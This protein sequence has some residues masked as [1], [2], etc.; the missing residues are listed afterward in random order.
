[1]S[2]YIALPDGTYVEMP[3][4]APNELVQGVRDKITERFPESAPKQSAFRQVADIPLQVARGAIGGVGSFAEAFGAN[5]PVARGLNT[6]EDYVSSYLS[7]QSRKDSNEMGRIMEEAKGKGVGENVLAAGRAFAVAPLDLIAQGA[8]SFFLPAGVGALS[9]AAKLGSAADKAVRGATGAGMVVGAVKSSIY[10]ETKKVLL[11]SGKTPEEAES[12]AQQ[13]Q[14]YGG[15]NLDQILAGAGLGALETLTGVDKIFSAVRA[16]ETTGRGLAGRAARGF[17]TE[18]PL[19]GLQ[20]GQE[21]LA[22]NLAVG[23]EGFDRDPFQGVAGRTALDAIVGGVTGS[24]IDVALGKRPGPPTT[25]QGPSP[26]APLATDILA[27]GA[28]EAAAKTPAE[29]PVESPVAPAEATSPFANPADTPE[30]AKIRIGNA[31]TL[32]GM[33]YTDGEI[34]SMPV[35]DISTVIAGGITP[36]Q[37]TPSVQ[38]PA[39]PATPTA[40]A[41][42][43][44]VNPN[45]TPAQAFG[46]E[47][48]GPDLVT[49]GYTPAQINSLPYGDFES[50]LKGAVPAPAAQTPA[51]Q[52]PAAQVDPAAQTPAAGATP[53]APVVPA[54]PAPAGQSPTAPVVPAPQAPAP[55]VPPPPAAPVNLPPALLKGTLRYG[56]PN[57]DNLCLNFANDVDRALFVV[58]K[59]KPGANDAKHVD[60]LKSVGFNDSEIQT[61]GRLLRA[62]LKYVVADHVKTGAYDKTVPFDFLQKY[63]PDVYDT[64]L[65]R[66]P[67][68]AGAVLPPGSTQ[69]PQKAP[70]VAPLKKPP[71]APNPTGTVFSVDYTT[72]KKLEAKIPGITNV[73]R[74]IHK[75]LFPGTTMVLKDQYTGA[76]NFG[77]SKFYGKTVYLTSNIDAIVNYMPSDPDAQKQYLL[78]V[79][80]HEMSHPIQ[81]AYLS[82]ATDAQFRAIYDQY[83]RMRNP[84]VA[85]RA[86]LLY[87]FSKG[88]KANDP[89]FLNK[90]LASEKITR[91]EF[92]TYVKDQNK[93]PTSAVVA[94]NGSLESGYVRSFDEWVGEQGAR[95]MTASLENLVPKTALQKFQKD[96]LTGLRKAYDAIASALGIKPTKGAFEK[97]MDSMY[98][99][100]QTTTFEKLVDPKIGRTAFNPSANLPQLILFDEGYKMDQQQKD[101][102]SAPT[103]DGPTFR[104]SRDNV[105]RE[106][107]EQKAKLDAAKAQVPADAK[108]WDSYLDIVRGEE[109][110]IKSWFNK[111]MRNLVGA[112]PGET[113]GRALLRNTTLSNE[114]FLSRTETKNLGKFLESHQNSTG[115]VMGV[116]TI[117]PLG[118]DPKTKSFFYHDGKGDTSLLKI[119]EK[120]G[121]KNMQ[122]AQ[123][124]MLAQREL[125]LRAA[126][127]VDGK[128]K[129]GLL[130]HPVTGKYMTD[131][132]LQGIVRSASPEVLQASKEFQKFNDKMVEM[133]IQTGL[134]PRSLGEQ[135]KTLMYTPMYRY[136]DE[137]LKKDRNITLGGDI[138][139]AIKDPDSI[140]AFNKQLASGGAVAADLYQNLLRNYNAIVSAAIRNVAYQET[141]TTL[142]KV[143]A[144]DGDST[145]GEILS[146]PGTDPDTG[147]AT[148]TYRVGGEDRHLL[149]HDAPMFQA[150]AALSPQEKNAFVRATSFY[151]GL[152]RTGVTSTPGF[153]LVNLIRGLVEL[154]IK[155]GMPVLSII[156][157]TLG[158]VSDVW[159]KKGAY[160]DIV[161]LTG[162]GGFGFGSGY[163]NQADYMKREYLSK[164]KPLNAW[165]GFLRAFD[166]LE[167]I[168]EVTEMAPRIAYYNYLLSLKDKSGGKMSKADAAWEAVNLVN[169]HR[170]GAGNGILGNAISNLI[171]LTPFLTA[172]IQGLYRLVET[173]TAGAPKSLVGKGVIGIPA[174]IVTRGLMVMFINAGVNAMYGDD[175]WY[176]KLSVKDRMSNMYVK[177]GDTVLALPRA[178]EVGELFG[179]LPTLVLD[180]IRKGD[181]NDIAV[182]V[183]EF[184]KKTFLF[185]PIPQFAKPIAEIVANKNF[186]T[187]QPIENLTDRQRKLVEERY[188]EYTSSVAKYA[189]LV[190]KEVGLSPKQVDTLIRG[191]LGTMATLFLG[192][193]DGVFS[194][195][196]TRPAGV[197]G[198]PSS[199]PGL[200][201][202][203]SGV[204]RIL[205][206][207]GQLNNKFIGDFYDI[208]QK[209]TE[210]TNSMT[211]AARIGDAETVKKRA[212]QMPA[213]KGLYTA[214]NAANENLSKINAQMD[215]IRKIPNLTPEQK[216]EYL[217]R[218]RKAKGLL[219]EQMVAAAARVGVTP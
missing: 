134:I 94:A 3:D 120:V 212:D 27:E 185:E 18:A 98:G 85:E 178:Y 128:S 80:F 63:H 199:V 91:Q 153:Q 81:E 69:T 14:A 205:K 9:R 23:R 194:A 71:A 118:Y 189:G 13:A 76:S 169:Y 90:F 168:G 163:K 52:T 55:K 197:F 179:A 64:I 145:I 74:E 57:K 161:G 11:E 162:F 135:F 83:V 204:S 148:I 36:S 99:K 22:A 164:E 217:E 60:W 170:H 147:R 108:G 87:G 20:G 88:I 46:R 6:A 184:A 175:E 196:G 56:A 190:T 206:T 35:A 201:A 51:A 93:F 66:A 167:H 43:T 31:A 54:S 58:S 32:Q 86:A 214:F 50:I 209:V 105:S 102:A 151:T 131:G 146:K 171:P 39:T 200:L 33:G 183:A 138:Y 16:A 180:S 124:V 106:T 62:R 111:A 110:G 5:N 53:T 12:A 165:N 67:G 4:N 127:Q 159:N 28:A 38:T 104:E 7:A 47:K 208:K 40:P 97:F 203:V 143:M 101:A 29:T 119:F 156:R 125:A 103:A 149:I 42:A 100:N 191:Y 95:W 15:K 72:Q 195:G 166:K 21:Q 122:Q 129:T 155:T 174:A 160:S 70:K 37:Y 73:L 19:E 26:D 82:R 139:D 193:V 115:R 216:T 211:E 176:K 133:A 96:V 1:M 137:V 144:N 92:D 89:L 49:L 25:D 2:Y 78:K 182:G 44:F 210:I 123:I 141:A 77:Q 152:L 150:I 8:G 157:G 30:D 173:G 79:L 41:T 17:I 172:R 202:N 107:P 154:K 188:D 219:A 59:S 48:Y 126:K 113:L 68:S 136:Q 61:W 10:E 121:V 187:G 198:D 24:A 213:A 181:G 34:A 142:S 114:P 109:P 65:N 140:S 177:V 117:G 130:Y 84:S 45:D 112:E 218:L 75:R 158:A 215:V 207:E 186:F 192:T 132:E 116:V